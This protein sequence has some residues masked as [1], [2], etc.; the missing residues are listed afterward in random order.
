MKN[1]ELDER[2]LV[3]LA[4]A[5]MAGS[6][7]AP[8]PVDLAMIVLAGLVMVVLVVQRFRQRRGVAGD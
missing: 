1:G 8:D 2:R 5:L 4:I 6:I 3:W 7:L